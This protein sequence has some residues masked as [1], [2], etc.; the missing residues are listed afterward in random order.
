VLEPVLGRLGLPCG[1]PV[2]G[3]RAVPAAARRRA[4][5]LREAR[6]RVDRSPSSL[7][8]AELVVDREESDEPLD[9]DETHAFALAGAIA[10]IGSEMGGAFYLE[11]LRAEA[12]ALVVRYQDE[13]L[14]V[15]DALE[16]HAVL[17]A[18]EVAALVIAPPRR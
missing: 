18:D 1:E 11:W 9:D 4:F 5:A 15:A 16:R 6:D 17:R 7:R 2:V 12:R 14:R 10:S 8:L 3:R 13:I